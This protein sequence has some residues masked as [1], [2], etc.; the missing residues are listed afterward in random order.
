MLVSRSA[1][2][3]NSTFFLHL[4]VSSFPLLVSH[5]SGSSKIVGRPE[6]SWEDCLDLILE[7]LVPVIKGRNDK[8]LTRQ[9]VNFA[10]LDNFEN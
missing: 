5:F 2:D 4:T 8:T 6:K 9:E 3:I 1:F 7:L 10:R